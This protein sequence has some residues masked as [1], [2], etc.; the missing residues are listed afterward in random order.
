MTSDESIGLRTVEPRSSHRT[1]LLNWNSKCFGIVC[2]CALSERY[3]LSISPKAKGHNK[4]MWCSRYALTCT[5]PGRYALYTGLTTTLVL[6][7][8]A[9]SD[10]QFDRIECGGLCIRTDRHVSDIL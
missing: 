4:R 3:L 10:S 8:R 7:L 9:R 5:D 1:E 2:V 6:S